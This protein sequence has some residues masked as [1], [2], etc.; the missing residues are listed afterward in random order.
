M[1]KQGAPRKEAPAK[2]PNRTLHRRESWRKASRK[3]Y[4]KQKELREKKE[5]TH[6]K[7]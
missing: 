3:Y 4:L 1:V 7:K 2:Q 5:K 6:K